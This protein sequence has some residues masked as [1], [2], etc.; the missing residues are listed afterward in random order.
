MRAAGSRMPPVHCSRLPAVPRAPEI[1]RSARGH[2]YRLA[3]RAPSTRSCALE[4][5][6]QSTARRP[7]LRRAHVGTQRAEALAQRRSASHRARART[8]PASAAHRRARPR[9]RIREVVR[10]RRHPDLRRLAHALLREGER[11]HVLADAVRARSCARASRRLRGV[12]SAPH[13]SSGWMPRHPRRR[14]DAGAPSFGEARATSS[15]SNDWLSA[16]PAAISAWK[17][18]CHSRS[19]SSSLRGPCSGLDRV[20]DLGALLHQVRHELAVIDLLR[21]QQRSRTARMVSAASRRGRRSR[22]LPPRARRPRR[23]RVCPG[24]TVAGS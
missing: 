5:G 16:S 1:T 10:R 20:D 11:R 17:S 8:A 4:R 19:P 12:S 24:P 7:L 14:A 15:M 23:L 13:F 18:T 3:A 22:S 9:L 6:R 2:P 21:P